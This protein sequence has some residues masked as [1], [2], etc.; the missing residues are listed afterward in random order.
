MTA[1]S[2]P[3]ASPLFG[4]P[5]TAVQIARTSGDHGSRPAD[6]VEQKTQPPY[7]NVAN[8]P[9]RSPDGAEARWRRSAHAAP[10]PSPPA[11][12]GVCQ[13]RISLR[14]TPSP[15]SFLTHPY[16]GGSWNAET[17]V[18]A[19]FREWAILGSNEGSSRFR[20]PKNRQLC[21]AKVCSHAR[22]KPL[23]NAQRPP[24]SAVVW[25]QNGTKRVHASALRAL[26]PDPPMGWVEPRFWALTGQ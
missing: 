13:K 17:P 10:A 8:P 9:A 15:E 5:V 2:A 12:T 11:M 18:S 21:Q 22:L 1:T 6:P 26:S 23:Q 3:P 7:A 14:V 19:G 24:Q 4:P 25:H 20:V 16:L